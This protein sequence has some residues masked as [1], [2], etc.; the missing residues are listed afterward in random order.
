MS[1]FGEKLPVGVIFDTNSHGRFDLLIY[2]D[3]ILGVR[4]TFLGVA[5]RGVGAGM[6]GAGGSGLGGATTAGIGVAG[7]SNLG[8]NLKGKRV[9]RLLTRPRSKILE[10]HVQNFFVPITGI[11]VL[12]LHKSWSECSLNV[13]T[14]ENPSGRSFRWKPALNSF[15]MV[16]EVITTA[17]GDLLQ[18]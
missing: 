16:R 10:L 1:D 2:P 14:S 12:Q 11:S 9:S 17:F 15:N 7:G 3:G 4:G 18:D 6:V 13:I 8:K 5:L